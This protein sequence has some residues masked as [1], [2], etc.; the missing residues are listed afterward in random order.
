MHV[1]VIAAVMDN[2]ISGEKDED[3]EVVHKVHWT[4]LLIKNI[5]GMVVK[6]DTIYISIIKEEIYNDVHDIWIASVSINHDIDPRI[7][8]HI[9]HKV[10]DA[11]K[12]LNTNV[13]TFIM[14]DWKDNELDYMQDYMVIDFVE[15]YYD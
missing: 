12:I 15:S 14:H 10:I 3:F 9:I 7:Y 1:V 11:K 8:T 5:A 2:L 4:I 13:E 6:Q